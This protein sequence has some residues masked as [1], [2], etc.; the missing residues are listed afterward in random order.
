MKGGR[1]AAATAVTVLLCMCELHNSHAFGTISPARSTGLW[2]QHAS[3]R[4]CFDCSLKAYG[5]ASR[6]P[7]S[8]RLGLRRPVARVA[9]IN[10]PHS[11]PPSSCSVHAVS[12]PAPRARTFCEPLVRSDGKSWCTTALRRI[13]PRVNGSRKQLRSPAYLRADLHV[14][15]YA[16][17]WT[18]RT[19]CAHSQPAREHGVGELDKDMQ[20]KLTRLYGAPRGRFLRGAYGSTHFVVEEPTTGKPGKLK[21]AVLSHGIGASLAAWDGDGDGTHFQKSFIQ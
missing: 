11:G 10:S 20:D 19:M 3:T 2:P 6:F 21:V 4:A 15:T 14:Y 17:H 13:L 5:R 7:A 12:P 18:H 16:R 9:A 8:P 1:H